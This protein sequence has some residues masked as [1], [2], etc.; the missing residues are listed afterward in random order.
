MNQNWSEIKKSYQMSIRWKRLGNTGK[1]FIT[2]IEEADYPDIQIQLEKRGKIRAYIPSTQQFGWIIHARQKFQS[3]FTYKSILEVRVDPKTSKAPKQ[4]KPIWLSLSDVVF[5]STRRPQNCTLPQTKMSKIVTYPNGASI[6]LS[7]TEAY[8]KNQTELRKRRITTVISVLDNH[9][10]PLEAYGIQ[11]YWFPIADLPHHDIA[12]FFHPTAMIILK[13][14]LRG[15]NVLV[16]CFKGIS[17][18]ATLI[19]AFFLQCIPCHPELV[20]PY[21]PVGEN[22]TGRILWYMRRKRCIVDP[23]EGFV[24][25]LKNLE[26]AIYKLSPVL[27]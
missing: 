10:E 27:C 19:A 13:A 23:N 25:S 15:E 1:G 9:P 17:R 18:S 12:P 2:P 3:D 14:V 26:Q 4:P 16:H 8:S 11:Q 7:G 5:Y 21:I 22:M 24:Q 20:V 6:Y